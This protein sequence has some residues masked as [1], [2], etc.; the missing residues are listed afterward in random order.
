MALTITDRRLALHAG[1][2]LLVDHKVA[3]TITLGEDAGKERGAT[4]CKST[5]LAIG[6][7]RCPYTDEM[8]E[9]EFVL[10]VGIP[11][12]DLRAKTVVNV[13]RSLRTT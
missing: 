6:N 11:Q 12:P 2:A 3:A 7:M 4:G 10:H 5:M 8:A 13:M 1:V 9:A